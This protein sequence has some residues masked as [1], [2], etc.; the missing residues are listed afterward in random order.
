MRVSTS[1]EIDALLFVAKR[2]RV[3]ACAH[4]R[5]ILGFLTQQKSLTVFDLFA[6]NVG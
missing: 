3:H 5:V 1:D 6:E 2:W 4:L